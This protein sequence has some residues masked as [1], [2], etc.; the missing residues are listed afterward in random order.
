MNLCDLSAWGWDSEYQ[1]AYDQR[2]KTNEFCCPGRVISQR[3]DTFTVVTAEGL[4]WAHPAGILFHRC[5]ALERPG[6]GDWVVLDKIDCP[7]TPEESSVTVTH[8]VVDVLP[9]KACFVREAPGGRGEAQLVATNVDK[10]FI[11]NSADDVNLNRIERFAVAICAGSARPALILSKGDLVTQDELREAKR[12]VSGIMED[13][14]VLTSSHA[15]SDRETARGALVPVLHKGKTYALVGASGAGKSTLVNALLGEDVQ[16]TGSVRFGDRKGRH[17]TSFRELFP[18]ANGA[19]L[20]DTPG[21]REFGLWSH[22]E[23]LDEVFSDIARLVEECRFSDCSH[24]R[25][26]GCAVLD[27][28][29]RGALTQRRLDHWKS[30]TVELVENRGRRDQREARRERSKYRRKVSRDKRFSGR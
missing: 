6:V 21:V 20:M 25:E 12:S 3:E 28:V 9:R 17:V 22:G 30:L 23:G 14:E 18:L 10:V 2:A 15:S 27:A 5:A 13:F 7:V 24:D 19:L 26:P 11:V 4:R 29:E 8:S 1:Q 16:E